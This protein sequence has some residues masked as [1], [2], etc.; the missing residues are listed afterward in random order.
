MTTLQWLRNQS[1]VFVTL[2]VLGVIVTRVRHPERARPFR[3]PLYPLT[4]LV[5]VAVTGW[6]IVES[7]RYAQE[8]ALFGVATIAAGG[9]LYLGLRARAR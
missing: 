3:V 7:I 2:T 8:V 5:F 6:T 9:A 1:G 4:P